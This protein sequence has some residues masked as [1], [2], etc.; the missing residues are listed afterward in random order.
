MQ[1]SPFRLISVSSLPR[2]L[3]LLALV[4]ALPAQVIDP[5][6]RI[7]LPQDWTHRHVVFNRQLL[8]RHPELAAAE[9]RVLHQFLQR[10]PY[11]T[12]VLSG[13]SDEAPSST[14]HRDWSVNLGAGKVAFGMSP[15]KYGFDVNAPPAVPTTLP[16]SVWMSPV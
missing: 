12:A 15:V 11:S 8:S 14:M 13:V 6:T 2:I 10:M 3:S 9:P 7:G 5:P 16:R 1:T 4:S